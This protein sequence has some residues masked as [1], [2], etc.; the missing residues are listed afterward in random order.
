VVLADPRFLV[1]EPVEVLDEARSRCRASVGSSSSGWN[2]AR[3]MPVRNGS[4]VLM[5]PQ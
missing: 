3:K 2:G 1:A 4:D 5:R